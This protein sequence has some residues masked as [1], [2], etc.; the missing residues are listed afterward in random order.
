MLGVPVTPLEGLHDVKTLVILRTEIQPGTENKQ[1]Y[2]CPW[3]I[4][5]FPFPQQEKPK[6]LEPLDYETVIE[7]LEKTYRNDPLRDL[8]FFPSDDFSVS[9]IFSRH[10]S[11]GR[12][13]QNDRRPSQAGS[14]S[15]LIDSRCRALLPVAILR[16]SHCSG[17]PHR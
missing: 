15:S 3:L 9:I 17:K 12:G 11:S 14:L 8:L 5:Y 6:L 4:P 1:D 7:E 13:P 10:L 16:H 2:V